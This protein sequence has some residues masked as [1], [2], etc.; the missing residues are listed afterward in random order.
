MTAVDWPA[1]ATDVSDWADVGKPEEFRS[2]DGP[3]WTIPEIQY[4]NDAPAR[5]FV[6]GTQLRDGTI[7]ERCIRL[8]G[9]AWEDM[10]ASD[11]A[12]TLSRALLSAADVLDRLN[13]QEPT[14]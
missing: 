1:G 13:G 2:F 5:V 11:T 7:E 10:L 9:V 14:R 12:R 6:S 3:I 4:T 8:E